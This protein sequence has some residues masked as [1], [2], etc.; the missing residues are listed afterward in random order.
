M[1]PMTP[2]IKL[3]L[4]DDHTLF[5]E[6]LGRL[7]EAEP[8]L[9]LIG[10]FSSVEAALMELPGLEVDLVLLDFDLG[11]Q[12]GLDLLDG[13]RKKDFKGRV[14][15]VTAG[16]SD[17]DTFRAVELG[18]L[19]IFLKH[20]PPS[21]LLIAIRKVAGGET[22]LAPAALRSLVAAAAAS[23][24]QRAAQPFSL[25]PRERAALEAVFEGLTNKEIALRLHISESYVKA[26]LQQLFDKTGVRSRSQLVRFALEKQAKAGPL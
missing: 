16:M 18:A 22:W 9:A 24:A 1:M 26:I 5:R 3:V 10:G 8:D 11:K 19:G 2:K 17:S 23:P 12:C 7:L 25:T 13:L 6:S 20:S 14:L 4:V 21:E 15:I